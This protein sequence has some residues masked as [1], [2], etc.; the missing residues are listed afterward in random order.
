MNVLLLV[1]KAPV[2]GLAKTRLCPPADPAQAAR[3]AAAALLDTLAAVRATASTIPVLAHTG[4][5]A[6]AEFGAA[7]TAALTGWHLIPQRGD[8]FVDRLANAHA[9]TG[10]AF[11]GRPVLQ[12]GMD[13]PQVTPALLTA[14]LERLAEHEAVFGPA[15]DGGWWALGLRDP[16]NGSVLRDVP[17]STADTGRRTLAALRGRGVH[18]AILPVLRDV[19]DW[20]TALAVAADLPGTRF[21]DAVASVGGQ[22]V[23]GRLR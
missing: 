14:A 3:I 1:A 15:L 5:F 19:D 13:T 12:I 22:L 6:D 7:L 2:R 4:L 8:T 11:P 17:M 21:A 20:P 23:S 16:A 18:P 9:D 10:M